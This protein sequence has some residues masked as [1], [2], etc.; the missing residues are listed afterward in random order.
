MFLLY[1]YVGNGIYK[2]ID[3]KWTNR[4]RENMYFAANNKELGI[5][6]FSE[7]LRVRYNS[8]SAY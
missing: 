6:L 4:E 5:K 7:F 2:N 8:R 3:D 1:N